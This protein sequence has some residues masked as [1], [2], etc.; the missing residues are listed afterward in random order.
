MISEDRRIT[1]SKV[2]LLEALKLARNVGLPPGQIVECKVASDGG[3]AVQIRSGDGATANVDL[4][5]SQ[6]A[7]VFIGYARTKRVPVPR[8]AQKRLVPE[9][10]G[11]AMIIEM[12]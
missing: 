6:I 9:G 7:A 2:A 8:H 11:I 10:D 1:M 12:R 4:S 5:P 3:C